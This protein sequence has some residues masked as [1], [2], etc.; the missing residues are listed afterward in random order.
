MLTFLGYLQ[1]ELLAVELHI[2]LNLL[3]GP[4]LTGLRILWRK[5][6]CVLSSFGC[7]HPIRFRPP[8]QVSPSLLSRFWSLSQHH[9]LV[10]TAARLGAD[11]VLCTPLQASPQNRFL[12][13]LWRDGGLDLTVLPDCTAVTSC[14]VLGLSSSKY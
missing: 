3:P 6:T 14:V 9:R 12:C 4:D 2:T 5:F 7:E 1:A 11:C 8:W 13:L 10:F